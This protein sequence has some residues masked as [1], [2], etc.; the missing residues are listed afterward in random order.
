M[1]A[2]T[3]RSAAGRV[4]EGTRNR[5]RAP[6]SRLTGVVLRWLVFVVAL[7][8]WQ[9]IVSVA[10][11]GEYDLYF[12]PPSTIAR[13]MYELWLS[14]PGAHAF[15]TAEATGNVI[16]S[17]LRMLAGWG[18][19]AV[20][21]IT[22]GLL[23]GRSQRA[24]DYVDPLIQFF[25]TVPPP[26]LIPVFIVVFKIGTGMRLAVIVFG[27][28]WPILLNSIE[29]ARS[30]EPL[31]LDLA[32]VFNVRLTRRL[33][34]IILPA[35]APKIFAGLRVSLSLSIILMVISEMVGATDGI[36]LTLFNAKDSFLL[37]DM[38]AVIVLLGS[39]GYAFNTA[40]LWVE[41]H[42]LAWHRGERQVD[43]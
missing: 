35:T 43:G 30:V 12:P 40:L 10:V 33:T 23:L 2:A 18:I 39:L 36:G 15:L 13:R 27:V 1:S 9:L 42:F 32:R 34:R 8:L 17:I 20:L 26:A 28:V 6:R 5:W 19:A 25:R 41:R 11:T 4:G 29:G 22:L 3:T 14:G 38:W 24:L 21:G 37:P 16:P 31:R 7:G